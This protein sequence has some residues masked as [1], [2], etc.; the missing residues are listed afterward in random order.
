MPAHIPQDEKNYIESFKEIVRV[1]KPGGKAFLAPILST[2]DFDLVK[3]A[4][5]EIKKEKPLKN[6]FTEGRRGT[7]LILTKSEEKKE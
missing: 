7:I 2:Y 1:L 5:T 3:Q 4:I 6:K